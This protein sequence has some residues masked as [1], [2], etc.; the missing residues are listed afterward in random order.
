MKQKIKVTITKNN[1][2]LILI[3]ALIYGYLWQDN[4]I[5]S[6]IIGFVK[7]SF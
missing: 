4:R 2:I 1:Q 6:K 3:F 5:I 7:G